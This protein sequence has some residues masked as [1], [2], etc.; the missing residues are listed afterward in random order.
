M[1]HLLLSLLI[2]CSTSTPST[3][4]GEP[5]AASAQPG[6]VDVAG[7]KAAVDQGAVVIDVRT[8]DEYN[9]GH[10]PGARHIPLNELPGKLDQINDLQDKEVYLICASGG[11]SSRATQL[12]SREGFQHPINVEGGTSAWREAGYPLD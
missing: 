1:L 4:P 7:L 2:A 12:L 10:V 11:R 6:A 3:S 5:A 9:S 8:D